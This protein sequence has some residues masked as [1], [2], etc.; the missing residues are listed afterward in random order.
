MF[1]GFQANHRRQLLFVYREFIVDPLQLF[2]HLLILTPLL[3]KL[4]TFLLNLVYSLL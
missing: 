3:F 2:V 4:V 1:L